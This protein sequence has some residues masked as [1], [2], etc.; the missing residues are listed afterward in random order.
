[1]IH[2]AIRI[3]F[4]FL[5]LLPI[6]LLGVIFTVRSRMVCRNERV[7]VLKHYSVYNSTTQIVYCKFH[8]K[9]YMC[10]LVDWLAFFSFVSVFG[11]FVILKQQLRVL[12]VPVNIA[13]M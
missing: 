12:I 2:F 11:V 1:M 3:V 5:T 7:N 9:E 13:N 8:F 10:W 6:S 4:I